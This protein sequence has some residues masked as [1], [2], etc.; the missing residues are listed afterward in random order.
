M[1]TNPSLLVQPLSL[2]HI[3]KLGVQSGCGAERKPT[4]AY[5][6]QTYDPGLT[7]TRL[8]LA[9]LSGYAV[10]QMKNYSTGHGK[11]TWV[12]CDVEDMKQ[13]TLLN[14]LVEHHYP[15]RQ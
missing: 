2:W 13:Y 1:C 5:G 14:I 10:Y 7:D 15:Q 11:G 4:D 9:S 6:S 12:V 3:V 8:Q